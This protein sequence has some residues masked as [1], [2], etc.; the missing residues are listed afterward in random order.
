NDSLDEMYRIIDAARPDGWVLEPEA[1]RLFRL[2]GFDVP[3]F[4]LA[5]TPEE[6]VRFAHEIGYPVVAKV[7]SPR[8]LHKT[9]VGGVAVGIADAG[10][11]E[12]VFRRFQGMEGFIG[13][14][15][16]EIVS[17]VELI[18]G[19]K[20]DLQFGPMILLGMGGIGVEIYQDVALRMAPLAGKDVRSMIG[21][22][23]ARRLLEGYRGAEKVDR[24]KLTETILA[25]S[26]VVMELQG[27]I[28]SIDINPLLCSSRRCVV[29]DARIVL[30]K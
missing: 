13:M 22:L 27:R 1:K 2:A 24:E 23:K 30:G 21:G 16:E 5:R 9:D 25:F 4:M 3:R 18:L 20:I 28:E 19:A 8:I 14:M 12:E 10:R 29:A 11:L 6:A 7:V 26:S 15:V 17:G